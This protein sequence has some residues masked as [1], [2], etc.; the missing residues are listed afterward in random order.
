MHMCL[1]WSIFVAATF[2]LTYELIK[3]LLGDSAPAPI[4]HM[5]AATLG[6]VVCC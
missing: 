5:A 1:F 2:F 6:E 3:S 4:V